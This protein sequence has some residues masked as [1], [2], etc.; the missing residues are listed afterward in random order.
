MD[1]KRVFGLNN[2]TELIQYLHL[3]KYCELSDMWK[4]H[5][6]KMFPRIKD[7]DVIKAAHFPDYSAKPDIL[8]LVNKT[9]RYVS[10]KTGRTPTMHHEKVETFL[11]FLRQLGVSENTIRTINFYHYGKSEKLSN[12]GVAFT[13]EEMEQQFSK[14]FL[15]ASMELDKLEIIEAVIRRAILRGGSPD[16]MKVDHLIY[17][18]VEK[19][20]VLSL[21]DIYSLVS[22]YREHNNA[23]IH[24]GGLNYQADIRKED[25]KNRD[26][27]KITWPILSLLYYK[28]EE[29]LKDII[30]GN[31]KV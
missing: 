17:G 4:K 30:L 21:N 27:M 7:S 29:E 9:R 3:K 2:E 12:N 15:K 25:A 28:N 20:Y 24:F 19:C 10:V 13:K 16:K 6:K 14:Y 8:I 23:N 31:I 18:N 5:I 22:Q 11:S 1:K 26:E